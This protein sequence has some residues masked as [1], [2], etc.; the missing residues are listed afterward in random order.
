M[1]YTK[2]KAA[3]AAY[4][5]GAAEPYTAANWKW[6]DRAVSDLD[7]EVRQA[8][9]LERDGSRPDAHEKLSVEEIAT[10]VYQIE[11]DISKGKIPIPA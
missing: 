6:Y 7:Y 2:T 4:Y 11:R 1:Q 3:I 5:T 9:W 8:Y 10:R